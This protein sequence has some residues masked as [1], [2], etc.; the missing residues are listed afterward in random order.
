MIYSKKLQTF[1]PITVESNSFYI[2][3]HG[4]VTKYV[5]KD[6]KIPVGHINLR[7]IPE[8]VFVS[9]IQNQYPELYSKFGQIADQIEVEHCLKRG[10]N[11]FE[12]RSEAALNSH[13]LHYLRGKRFDDK[14]AEEKIREIIANTP[15]GTLY[16]TKSLGSIAM[17]MPKNLINKYVEAIKKNPLILKSI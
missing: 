5:V 4:N 17:Y 16:N 2:P 9:F 8:G 11:N 3:G 1:V 13:A 15:K 10:L 14:K 6:G 7:D 12:I